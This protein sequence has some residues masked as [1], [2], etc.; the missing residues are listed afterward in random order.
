MD[1]HVAFVGDK[2]G[3]GWAKPTSGEAFHG[4]KISAFCAGNKHKVGGPPWC[5][6]NSSDSSVGPLGVAGVPSLRN[7]QGVAASFMAREMN[8]LSD[9]RM[10]R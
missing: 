9:S 4:P 2:G 7:H 10:N 3:G 8:P 5:F 1:T 6:P